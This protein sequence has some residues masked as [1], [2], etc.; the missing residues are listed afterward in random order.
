MFSPFVLKA[1]KVQDIAK[2]DVAF[3]AD[4]D[5]MSF[6]KPRFLMIASSFMFG[7]RQPVL[8]AVFRMEHGLL[9]IVVR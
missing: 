9:F 8:V 2:Y 7:I 4:P 3:E 1:E 5:F 6:K